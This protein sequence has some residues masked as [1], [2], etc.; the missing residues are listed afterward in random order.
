M[1][2]PKTER[3]YIRNE[4]EAKAYLKSKGKNYTWVKA[5][6][7]EKYGW[8]VDGLDGVQA[9]VWSTP[10]YI[11]ERPV[12]KAGSYALA[13]ACDRCGGCGRHSHNGEHDICYG[14]GGDGGRYWI[15]A[16]NLA[17]T[18]RRKELA[19]LAKIR[20]A[21]K[22]IQNQLDGQRNWCE[23]NTEFGRVTFDEK[24]ELEL[25]QKREKHSHLSHVGELKARQEWE[26]MTL[27]S[28]SKKFESFY[29]EG[30]VRIFT[31]AT[32]EGNLV[33]W[34]SK[35]DALEEFDVDALFCFRATPVKHKEF[36]GKP[37]TQVNRLANLKN[38]EVA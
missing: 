27:V 33:I 38:M 28:Q 21:E 37:Q 5:S 20:K 19:Q 4:E 32:A 18:A 24:A 34:S 8:T 16:T 7:D 12:S 15:S 10:I 26:G 22:K 2:T 1:T 3:V 17:K 11:S 13:G 6:G 36:N 35:A 29:G 9:S 30:M 31:F 14:C 23:A 25:E